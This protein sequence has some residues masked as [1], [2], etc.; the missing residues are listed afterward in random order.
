MPTLQLTLKEGC[1]SCIA[2]GSCTEP[3]IE[4]LAQSTLPAVYASGD[5]AADILLH[6]CL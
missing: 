4:A 1:R 5:I 2:I 3:A 6:P